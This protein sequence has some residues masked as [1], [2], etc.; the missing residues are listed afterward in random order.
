MIMSY[1][2]IL[3]ENNIHVILGLGE[4]SRDKMIATYNVL[5]RLSMNTGKRRFTIHVVTP[6]PRPLYFET[7]RGLLSHNIAYTIIVRYHNLD[8][9]Q[10]EALIDKLRSDGKTI[11]GIITGD[12]R[13]LSEFLKSRNIPYEEIS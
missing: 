11:Y 9:K 13:E 4:N 5:A 6:K 8:T 3:E 12:L 10:L 2:K 1:L 7:L